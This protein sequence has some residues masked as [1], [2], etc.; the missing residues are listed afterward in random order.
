MLQQIEK[1]AAEGRVTEGGK[2][3]LPGL[4]PEALPLDVG[5]GQFQSAVIALA[6]KN[7]WLVYHTFD[8]RRSEPGFPDLVLVLNRV[9]FAELKSKEGRQTA[10]QANWADALVE[11]K[12]E[13]HFWR[14]VDWPVIV[15]IL[16][17]VS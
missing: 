5:E 12:A 17:G 4:M 10:E 13:F 9:I 3:V 2:T 15:R 7:G 1:A 16:E 8:S 11:A 14:P 6:K